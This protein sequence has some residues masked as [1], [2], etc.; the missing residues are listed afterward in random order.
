MVIHHMLAL[1]A[2]FLLSSANLQTTNPPALTGIWT[3]PTSDSRASAPHSIQV[4][5]SPKRIVAHAGSAGGHAVAKRTCQPQ[6]AC[7]LC[8]FQHAPRSSIW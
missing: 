2:G 3:T 1:A 6:D 5:C 7:G 4:R 8:P